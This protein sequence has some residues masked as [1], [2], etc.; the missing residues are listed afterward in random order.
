[1]F[2]RIR[3]V[4][5]GFAGPSNPC[6]H[7]DDVLATKRCISCQ[8]SRHPV[9]RQRAVQLHQ[10]GYGF[11]QAKDAE[12]CQPLSVT[13]LIVTC[14]P[15]SP[16]PFKFWGTRSWGHQGAYPARQAGG[17]G[18][19]KSLMTGATSSKREIATRSGSGRHALTLANR[20]LLLRVLRILTTISNMV[21]YPRRHE[22][23][24]ITP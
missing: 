15:S 4:A 16:F 11:P 19:S 12:S 20:S 21:L 2:N 14:P 9:S 3:I 1:M 17:R 22:R 23:L 24:P 5:Q 13:Q 10:D 6:G 8:C 18:I 7:D